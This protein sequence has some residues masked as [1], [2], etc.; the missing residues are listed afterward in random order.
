MYAEVGKMWYW[1]AYAEVEVDGGS[2]GKKFRFVR[3]GRTSGKCRTTGRRTSGKC[4]K[5]EVLPLDGGTGFPK[6]VGC[7]VWLGCPDVR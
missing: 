4:R 2:N 5:S 7:L 6:A 3:V 1:S